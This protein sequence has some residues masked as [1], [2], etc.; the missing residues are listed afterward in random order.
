MISTLV[1]ESVNYWAVIVGAVIAMALGMVW[2]G[3]ATFGKLWMKWNGL[4]DA[5]MS[6]KDNVGMLYLLQFV[7]ALILTFVLAKFVVFFNVKTF[8]D[9]LNL[10]FWLWLGFLVF[11]SAGV[12]IFPPKRWQLFLFDQSYKLVNIVLVAWMLGVWR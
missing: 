9:A 1:H 4:T 5:D 8:A 11:G 3:P 2:Y 12:Y 6:N 10:G 7:A